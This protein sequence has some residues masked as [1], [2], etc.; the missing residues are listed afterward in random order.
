MQKKRDS[1]CI[2]LAGASAVAMGLTA[3]AAIAQDS[4]EST[5]TLST[6]TVTTQ[7][8]EESIQDVPIAVSAFDQD[9]IERL[10]LTGGPDL[11]KSVPNVAFTKTNFTSFN[12]KVRGIGADA[13]AQSADA[14][15]GIHQNDIPLQANRLFES[16]FHDIERVE[17]LRGPQGT[18][19]G[20]NATGGVFNLITNKPVLEEWQGDLSLTYG[21]ENTF[22]AKGMVNVP[23]GER[24]ALRL[25]GSMLQRDGFVNNATTGNDIDDRDLFSIRA[26]LGFEPTDSFRGWISYE[27]FEEDDSRIRSGK[28]LCHKDE[29][30]TSF[31]GVPINPVD[32]LMTIRGCVD[33]PLNS[34]NDR[35][36]S[37]GTEAGLVS[38]LLG[39]SSGDLYPNAN[40]ADLRTI[41]SAFD[42][43]YEAEQ[44]LI[45]WSGEYDLTES[46]MLTY[47]GSYNETYVLSIEDYNKHA[48]V[49]G[50]NTTV[51]P[52]GAV[53]GMTDPVYQILFPGGVVSDPELGPLDRHVMFDLSSDETET[54][55]HEVRMQ[56]DFDSPFNFNI[57]AIY[58][59]FEAVDPNTNTDG[60]YV[61]SPSFTGLVQYNNLAGGAVIGAPVPL[62]TG[63]TSGS[64]F[65]L[66][67]DGNGG[68]YFRSIS[69]FRLESFAVFG[70]GYYDVSDELKLT[71]GL[72]YTDDQKEQDRVPTFLLSPNAGGAIEPTGVL[73][74]DFQEVTGRVG[75]DWS[76]DFGFTDDSLIYGFYSRGYKGGGIN[77][78]QPEGVNLYPELF[79][80]EFVNAYELGTKN[81]FAG[82]TAQLNLT[83]FFYDYTGYQI[84]QIINR[85]SV[86]LNV[87]AELT[88]LEAEFLWTPADN[89]L[90]TANL[91]LLDSSL[92]DT[93]GLDQK[94][95]INGRSDLVTVSGLLDFS[96]C[97]VSAQ[98]Y[99]T[100]LGAINAG[101]LPA[102][103]S[104][105][106]CSGETA[107][108]FGGIEAME[109][110][111]G[112]GGVTV[113][114]TDANG[115][116][117]TAS[118]LTPFD[119]EA[120]DLDGN[121][122]PGAPDVTLNLAAEYTIPSIANSGWDLT[123]RGDYYY[124]GESYT[125]VWNTV[126]DE[127]EDWSNVNLALVLA[128]ADNGWSVE[129]YAKNL[130]DEEVITGGY[131]TDDSSGLFSN[132][133]V[134]EPALYGVTVRKRW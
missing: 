65:D 74:A 103:A 54:I 25:A 39:L 30:I 33:G 57:G 45:S 108:A 91:G 80:P 44:T 35:V 40:I 119:G 116:T 104:W 72:R 48:P 51:G 28:Q 55:T 84:T 18:L 46:L 64:L 129:A 50:H 126:G 6:V 38:A 49:V 23:L 102:G 37:L 12:F 58:M 78:P 61:F 32:A 62:D 131:L 7:K 101:I 122:I 67:F 2:W 94:D 47:K 77:P 99:A 106:L 133:F 69:P 127:L 97:V 17:V 120:K 117:Q 75:F 15:V 8:V 86:N 128:N 59:D 43:N 98:G 63:S 85:S 14:G 60:Y 36:N 109:T 42:P 82:G 5:R 71:L 20:R 34:A 105:G 90:L 9:A 115:D 11:V 24:A 31:A 124:Q 130:T 123:I 132:V 16:E 13:I 52:F 110:A 3:P 125:R 4:P 41:E 134:S 26:T 107:A 10:Q 95:R 92:V 113:T 83:G 88:G 76:P 89:W 93:Y 73:T 112:L 21:N 19:Y 1:K 121:A 114:Y 79:D 81:T 27:H 118:A 100:V 96:N 66:S 111:L 22:K 68:N 70:E 87:D 53:L 56:S 29:G